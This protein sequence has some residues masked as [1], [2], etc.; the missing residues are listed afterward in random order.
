MLCYGRLWAAG[1]LALWSMLVV[2]APAVADVGAFSIPFATDSGGHVLDGSAGRYTLTFA[3]G[4]LPP[5]T[6]QWSLDMY[7]L[8]DQLLVANPIGRYSID[9]SML[10]ELKRDA[11][12]GLTVFVQ[13]DEPREGR[14]ANWLP[15]PDGPFLMIL[16]LYGAEQAVLDN[17]WEPPPV[18]RVAN[19]A[20]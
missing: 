18:E 2:A 7:A 19:D 14:A 8:P 15:A 1:A 5:V 4:A 13:Q 16:R 12:G 11:D 6:R 17:A 10:R 20:K 3:A 9:S